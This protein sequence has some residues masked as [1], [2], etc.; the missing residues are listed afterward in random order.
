MHYRFLI[1]SLLIHVILLAC[2]AGDFS[3]FFFKKHTVIKKVIRVDMV[4]LPELYSKTSF[5]TSLKVNKKKIPSLKKRRKKNKIK[6]QNKKKKNPLSSSLNQKKLR[7]QQK[8]A[9]DTLKAS[10]SIEKIKQDVVSLKYKGQKISKGKERQGALD[11]T[12]NFEILKYFTGVRLHINLYWR[13]PME[14]ANKNL[15]AKIYVVVN[16]KGAVL[17]KRILQSSG[18]EDFD[19]RVLETLQKASPLPEPPTEK[20]QN[21]LS[22][23]IV[24]N[25]PE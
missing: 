15:R 11:S 21:K 8:Q 17:N 13:L 18:N 4:G 14:L 1:F 2:V 7:A 6:K 22:N 3:K 25:F 10:E 23:G 9:I 20:I 12:D 5:N 16:K 19:A 24:F